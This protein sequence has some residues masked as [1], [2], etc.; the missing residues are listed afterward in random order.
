MLKALRDG[1]LKIAD[2]EFDCAVLD[3]GERVISEARFMEAMGMY[4]SGAL[5]TRR[6]R[7]SAGA[8]TPLFLAYKNLKPFVDKHLNSV[9][10][11]PVK[12]RT[13]KGGIGHG[14]PAEVIPVIC[15]IWIEADKAGVLGPR[16][17][18]IALKAQMLLHGLAHTGIIALVDE[19]TGYQ[20]DRA[21]QALEKILEKYIAQRLAEWAKTFP[22]EFYEEIFRLK[23][24]RYSASGFEKRPSVVGKYTNDIIYARLAPGVLDQLQ[25]LNPT[26]DKGQRKN[27]HHQWLTRDVGNPALKNH[28]IGVLA[29]MKAS[30]SWDSFKT[31]LRRVYPRCNEQMDLYFDDLD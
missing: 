17:K 30:K 18:A 15:R 20:S 26:D 28:L 8:Q 5:S 10:F 23:G 14:I 11:S 2:I 7:D 3:G 9:H 21:R 25:E 4:R 29:L 12:Y 22:D 13:V 24:W 19:A 6:D 27:R 1:C 31:A 16:Q